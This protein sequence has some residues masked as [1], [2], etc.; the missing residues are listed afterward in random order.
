MTVGEET[1]VRDDLLKALEGAVGARHVLTDPRRTRFYRTGFR[2][3]A[4]DALAVVRPG[5]LVEMW[6]AIEACTRFGAPMIVQAANTGLTGGSTPA[7]GG[8]D[9]PIVII[10]TL[11]IGGI[12]PI[13]EGRQ[14][15]CLPGATLHALESALKPLGREPHSVIGSSCFGASIVGGVCNNSGGSLVRRGVAYTDYALFARSTAD[16]GIELVNH[17]GIDLGDDPVEILHQLDTGAFP[18][19]ADETPGKSASDKDYASQVR[20]VDADTPARYNADKRCL[21][22]ASGSAGKLAVF[23]VRLDTFALEKDTHTFLVGCND[24]AQFA[25]LRRAILS[26][27]RPLPIAAEYLH[28]EAFDL[29]DTYGKDQFLLIEKL[30]TDRLPRFFALKSRVDAMLERWRWMPANAVDRLLHGLARWLPDHLSPRLREWRDRFEH[31]LL[32]K[33]SA[34]AVPE[35]RALLDEW[36]AGKDAAH[37]ECTPAEAAKAFLHR[38]VIAGAAIRYRALHTRQS[39]GV[40]SLDIALRRNDADWFETLPAEISEQ[41]AHRI[42]YGHF[43]CHVLHQDY[44]LTAGADPDAIKTAMLD[45]LDRRGARYPAEH[46]VGHTYPAAPNLAAFYEALD[47]ANLFNPGIG[48]TSRR[49][50]HKAG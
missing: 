17:L 26:D 18:R 13:N 10:S 34:G 5:S 24:P 35:M 1:Q 2:T 39:A 46:N 40:L 43:L 22:E 25:T 4:G 42:Y 16:G 12:T 45:L 23:A 27:D 14:A 3:A 7:P 15:I 28:R 44:V 29:A 19:M 9:R 33:V 8:Y 11:R 50:N 47:P 49:K 37:V 20:D 48:K 6:R 32:I 30:G 41:V 38:F 21:H 31:L 36:G